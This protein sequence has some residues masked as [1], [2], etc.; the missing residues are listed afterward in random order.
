M[1]AC[2]HYYQ[3]F[4]NFIQLQLHSNSITAAYWSFYPPL[5]LTQ[6]VPIETDVKVNDERQSTYSEVLPELVISKWVLLLSLSNDVW[7]NTYY[8]TENSVTSLWIKRYNDIDTVI[9]FEAAMTYAK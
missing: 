2:K 4:Y 6:I 3:R 5:S 9:I 7:M 1:Y 8:S